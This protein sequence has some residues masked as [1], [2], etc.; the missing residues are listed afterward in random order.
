MFEQQKRIDHNFSDVLAY[1]DSGAPA[2]ADFNRQSTGL[3]PTDLI[4]STGSWAETDIKKQILKNYQNYN[5]VDQKLNELKSSL[6]T[7]QYERADAFS[8]GGRS[9]S[10]SKSVAEL[11]QQA[12]HIC[13]TPSKATKIKD[14]ASNLLGQDC[15]YQRYS[16]VKTAQSA[17]DNVVELSISG[18]PAD[19][20]TSH[21]RQIA[22]AKHIVDATVE[23]DTIRNVCTGQGKIR[24]RLGEGEDI[25]QVRQQFIQ[26]GL[27]VQES[28]INP[29]KKPIFTYQQS[30][31][32]KS[33][34][35]TSIDY[36]L[37]RVQNLQSSDPETFGNNSHF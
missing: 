29:S 19:A 20:Q 33:P 28:K 36:K 9:A 35:R 37:S 10:H 25:E 12:T 7:H 13:K 32:E 6:D 5:T 26:A 31:M 2:A 21:I 18:L 11:S 17:N 23:H 34:A 22:G 8:Q 30:L 14:L 27:N 4:H 16:S 15:I 1:K 3:R 24:V